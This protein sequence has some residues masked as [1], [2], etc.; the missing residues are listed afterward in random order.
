M[1]AE[2]T[3]KGDESALSTLVNIV[4]SPQAAF[5]SIRERPRWLVAFVVVSVLYAI[6]SLLTVP[7]VVHATTVW[8]PALLAKDPNTASMPPDRVAQGLAFALAF[9]RW[10]WVA[11]P[12]I[13]L[14]AALFAA[15]VLLAVT[16]IAKGDAGFGRLFALYMNVAVVS[17]GLGGLLTGIIAFGRGAASFSSPTE[18]QAAIPSLAWLVPGAGP[19]LL[20]LLA[21]VNPFTIWAFVLLALGTVS[22][23]RVSRTAGYIAAAIA[24]FG[25]ILAAAAFAK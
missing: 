4:V 22:V 17:I 3:T 6:G 12:F 16:A 20:T 21:A 8:Y 9:V 19:K 1:N 13:V 14:L 25:G 11:A 7:A 15:L 18:V 2:A 23:A 10:Q 24:S 5:D